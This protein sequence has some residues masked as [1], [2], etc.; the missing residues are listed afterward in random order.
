MEPLAAR[1]REV[2]DADD[3]PISE[4]GV[5]SMTIDNQYEICFEC[6]NQGHYVIMYHGFGLY[7]LPVAMHKRL[8]TANAMGNYTGGAH[9]S[10]D[11][12]NDEL[13]MEYHILRDTLPSTGALKRLILGF[14]ETI[15]T[16]HDQLRD[17]IRETE[18]GEL[19]EKA[20]ETPYHYLHHKHTIRQK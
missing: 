20:V 11:P 18:R 12:G 6:H 15:K 16:W 9:F 14:L 2:F 8:L 4:Q 5:I 17:L 7:G 19:E 10:I 13:L 1:L 3:I